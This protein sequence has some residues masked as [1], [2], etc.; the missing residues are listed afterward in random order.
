LE[1]ERK[2]HFPQ[3]LRYPFFLIGL[4]IMIAGGVGAIRAS[5][6]VSVDV[7]VAVVGFVFLII[8]IVFR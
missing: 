1:R 3:A 7:T 8:A 4:V 6:P 2:F 5:L